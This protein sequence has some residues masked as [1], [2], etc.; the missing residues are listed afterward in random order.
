MWGRRK[1]KAEK[2][3][4]K[5]RKTYNRRDSLVVTHPTT[6]LPA[7]GLSTAERTGSPVFHTLWSYVAVSYLHKNIYNLQ[8]KRNRCFGS[9]YQSSLQH[10][11]VYSKVYYLPIP[12]DLSRNKYTNIIYIAYWFSLPLEIAILSTVKVKINTYC[13]PCSRIYISKIGDNLNP[14][15]SPQASNNP[16]HAQ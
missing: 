15:Y 13:R 10:Q 14:N 12:Q 11:L 4:K 7:C 6:N 3:E 1:Q 8:K 2:K 9:Q 16:L 5:K